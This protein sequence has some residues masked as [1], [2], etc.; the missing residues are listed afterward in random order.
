MTS[1]KPSQRLSKRDVEALLSSYDHDPVAALEIALR[2]LCDRPDAAFDE[3]LQHLSTQGLLSPARLQ[4]LMR[5][6]VDALD[7][8]ASE[9]NETRTLPS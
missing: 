6:E 9:L 4:A 8:L 1:P 2:R 3:L 5:R 7:S